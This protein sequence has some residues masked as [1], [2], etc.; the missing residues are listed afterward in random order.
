MA[1]VTAINVPTARLMS[2]LPGCS[3][4]NRLIACS[5]FLICGHSLSGVPSA[6]C[7]AFHRNAAKS[8]YS[9]ARFLRLRP[10]PERHDSLPHDF[11]VSDDKGLRTLRAAS[12]GVE[13]SE[14]K[15]NLPYVELLRWRTKDRPTGCD[16]LD[17]F[18][19]LSFA[20]I[21]SF[22]LISAPSVA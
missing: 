2:Q 15:G 14:Q 21:G 3:Q 19:Y 6:E 7:E 20:H 17:D 5:W 1:E 10:C 11:V 8:V 12:A 4:I 9:R 16:L 13:C 22:G 18:A